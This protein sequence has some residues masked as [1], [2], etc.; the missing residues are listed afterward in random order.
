LRAISLKG[1]EDTLGQQ[2]P[3]VS[4]PVPLSCD[5]PPPETISAVAFAFDGAQ[6]LPA[7]GETM[8]LWMLHA[9]TTR[10]KPQ[11]A[12]KAFQPVVSQLNF[13]W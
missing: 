5:T 11:R 12:W 3:N 7:S 4:P 8:R 1:F 2:L 9:T 10:I 6:L 13:L